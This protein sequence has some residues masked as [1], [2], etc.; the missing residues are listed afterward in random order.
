MERNVLI[1]QI[2]FRNWNKA[3]KVNFLLRYMS[4]LPSQGT[5]G[6]DGFPE[7][8][9]DEITD[10]ESLNISAEQIRQLQEIVDK[11]RG[12]TLQTRASNETAQMQEI[13]TQR[14]TVG[15]YIVNRILKPEALPMEKEREAAEKMYV[16][17]LPYKNFHRLPVGQKSAIIDGLLVDTAKSEYAESISTLALTEPIA[18]LQRLN[19]EYEKL[20]S[21]RSSKKN[22]KSETV[23]AAELSSDAEILVNN[24]NDFANAT[25]LLEPNEEASA[26]VREIIK[27]YD[28][29][30]KARNMRDSVRD[31]EDEDDNVE[32]DG[33]NADDDLPVVQ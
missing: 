16:E 22:I 10:I 4:K 15:K 7:I 13:D 6:D 18:E 3:E 17:I 33:G 2:S 20:E 28:N 31:E 30:R 24:M 8:H 9:S 1:P 32:G 25:T 26:F 29:A 12:L 27:L 21:Q 23:T 11:L 5:E 14:T 19:E